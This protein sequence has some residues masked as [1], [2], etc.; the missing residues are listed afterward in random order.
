MHQDQGYKVS[1]YPA[2][3][4]TIAAKSLIGRSSIL[5]KAKTNLE[6]RATLQRQSAIPSP[7]L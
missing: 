6:A 1:Y 4:I 3:E 2:A 5:T 7:T